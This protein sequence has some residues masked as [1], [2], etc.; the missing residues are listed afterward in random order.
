MERT[1]KMYVRENIGVEHCMQ[2]AHGNHL[3][4]P[5]HGG[6]DSW[7]HGKQ[8]GGICNALSSR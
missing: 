6:T 4:A 2:I 5:I 8:D 3:A 1:A 7:R